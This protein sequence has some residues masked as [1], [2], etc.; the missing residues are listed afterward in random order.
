MKLGPCKILFVEIRGHL[1]P[2]FDALPVRQVAL[3]G[4]IEP[5]CLIELRANQVIQLCDT[6][7]FSDESSC[8]T[9][10]TERLDVRSD[11]TELVCRHHLH[12]IEDEKTPIDLA[13]DLHLP[14]GW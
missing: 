10:F 13:D 14:F 3:L 8:Q 5:I 7:I 11:I 1:A 12:L 9:K 2:N 4:Q 6:Q